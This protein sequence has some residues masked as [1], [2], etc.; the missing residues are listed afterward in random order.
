MTVT[1][2]R[3]HLL[4]LDFPPKFGWNSCDPVALFDAPVV[5]Q[6]I[7]VMENYSRILNP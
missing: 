4:N 5:L 2:V 3:G 1:S 7:E 6:V